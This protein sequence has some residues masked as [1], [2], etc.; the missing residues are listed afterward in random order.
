MPA[1]CRANFSYGDSSNQAR[2][3]HLPLVKLMVWGARAADLSPR[4]SVRTSTTTAVR[5]EVSP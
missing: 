3:L 5:S 2:R 4:P 1:A